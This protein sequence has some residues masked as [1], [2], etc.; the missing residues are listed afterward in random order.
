M[1]LLTIRRAAFSTKTPPRTFSGVTY[2]QDYETKPYGAWFGGV[3]MLIAETEDEAWVAVPGAA[4]DWQ[5]QR[6]RGA[7]A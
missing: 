1:K 2:C 4:F 3:E 6:N 5:D 7:A